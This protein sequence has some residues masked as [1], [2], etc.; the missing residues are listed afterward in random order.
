MLTVYFS[1][2]QLTFWM[3]WPFWCED[4]DGVKE[5]EAASQLSLGKDRYVIL[6]LTADSRIGDSELSR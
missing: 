2:S 3:R 6:T 4:T 1:R 5:R